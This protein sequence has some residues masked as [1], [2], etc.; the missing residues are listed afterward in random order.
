MRIPTRRAVVRALALHFILGGTL[1]VSVGGMHPVEDTPS[2]GGFV[3]SGVLAGDMRDGDI[4]RIEVSDQAIW[5]YEAPVV[6]FASPAPPQSGS[7]RQAATVPPPP[8]VNGDAVVEEASK[9]V[10]TPYLHGG[11]TP[12][13]FD[14]SG[15]VSYVYAQF[16]ISLPHS[17]SAYWTV[18]TRVSAEDARPGDIIVSS[19]HV[20]IYAGGGLQIDAPRE[21][22]TVQFR[23]IWQTSYIFVRV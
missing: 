21:G 22:K 11:T 19:G 23:G 18:G 16:G 14:C 9:Y 3:V 6:S 2:R 17:S 15:F 12:A 20:A 10:G 1:L 7:G 8:S 4:A 5:R 13:G